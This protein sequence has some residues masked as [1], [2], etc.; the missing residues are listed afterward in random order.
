MKRVNLV[1]YIHP[2]MDILFLALNA[3]EVS[4]ANAHW[5]TYNLSFWNLLFKAGI[6][7]QSIF[8]K[9]KGDEL[10]FGGNELNYRNWNIGVTDLNR[11]I[12]ETNSKAVP[13]NKAQVERI[14]QILET[15]KTA[16][17]CLMHS[18]VAREFALHG[19]ITRNF[20]DGENTFGIVGKYIKTTI[21]EVPFHSGN[22]YSERENYYKLL[23]E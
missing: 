12:V 17:L 7:T 1:E 20:K 22:K 11:D 13:K 14:L 16:R 21:Y 5:F 15:T 19:V 9:L 2:K 6:I 18:D 10:I 3:P 4:N 23:L 8:D